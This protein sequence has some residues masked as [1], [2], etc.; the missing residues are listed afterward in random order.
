MDGLNQ[1]EAMDIRECMRNYPSQNP[2]VAR[3][4]HHDQ[5]FTITA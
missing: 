2:N 3:T 5:D 1:Q 4:M